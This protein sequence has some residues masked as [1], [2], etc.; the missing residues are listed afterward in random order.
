MRVVFDPNARIAGLFFDPAA[1][2]KPAY[3][4]AKSIV[5]RD[6]TIGSGKWE[7]PGTLALPK[8]RDVVAGVVFVPSARTRWIRLSR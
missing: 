3:L 8:E 2:E 7:L 4:Q 6:V 5:E 1:V